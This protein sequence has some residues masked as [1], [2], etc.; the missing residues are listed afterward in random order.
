MSPLEQYTI[1]KMR[2]DKNNATKLNS[3]K[4]SGED[5]VETIWD[6][7]VYARELEFSY[8]RGLNHLVF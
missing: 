2:G 1:K 3:S 8:L 6:S 5:E 7:V 4:D